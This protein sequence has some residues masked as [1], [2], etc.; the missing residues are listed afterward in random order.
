M[1]YLRENTSIPVPEVYLHDDDLDGIVGGPWMVMEFVSP[2]FN[3][4][5]T[6]V[7][8]SFFLEG[9]DPSSIVRRRHTTNE[10]GTKAISNFFRSRN[11]VPTAL[12]EVRRDRQPQFWI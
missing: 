2:D 10:Y 4:P 6:S 11:L 9:K 12:A 5:I 1:R 7:K 3:P 8:V